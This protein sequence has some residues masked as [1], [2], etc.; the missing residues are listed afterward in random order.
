[1]FT[2]FRLILLLMMASLVISMVIAIA[3]TLGRRF[4]HGKLK[5]KA[6]ELPSDAGIRDLLEEGR[7]QEAIAAY[8]QFTGVDEFTAKK[9]I[10]VILREMQFDN[11]DLRETVKRLLKAGNKAGAIEAYQTTTGS[12]LAEAL[13]YVETQATRRK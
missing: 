10:D 8:R 11:N 9:V 5:R 4:E 13:E 6:G 7:V 12:T 2:I 1:M 3:Y